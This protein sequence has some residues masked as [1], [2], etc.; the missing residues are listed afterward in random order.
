MQPPIF[1]ICAADPAVRAMLGTTPTRLWPFGEAPEHA[2]RPYCVW[3]IVGGSPEAYLGNRPDIDAFAV[4]FDIYADNSGSATAAAEAIRDAI[5]LS[6][7][8]TR[9]GGQSKDTETGRYRI[10]FDTDWLT[11]R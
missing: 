10:S 3:Q 11:P 8:I 5:E 7:Y 2:Q 9:W 4:Q 1:P 6:A